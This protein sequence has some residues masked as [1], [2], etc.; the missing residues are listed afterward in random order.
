MRAYSVAR[1]QPE[2]VL[3]GARLVGRASD[4]KKHPALEAEGIN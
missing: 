2:A 1:A 4:Y 3:F